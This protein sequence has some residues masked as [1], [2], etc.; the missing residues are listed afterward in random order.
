MVVL[1]ANPRR[2]HLRAVGR[3]SIPPTARPV[4][5]G[6]FE[7]L[8]HRVRFAWRA[9][10]ARVAPWYIGRP[11]G[12]R[13]AQCGLGVVVVWP[14]ALRTPPHAGGRVSTP[15]KAR[16]IGG[17]EL[18][19]PCSLRFN[20]FNTVARGPRAYYP[21]KA[22]PTARGTRACARA[23]RMPAARWKPQL[24]RRTT[25]LHRERD[26]FRRRSTL[27]YCVNRSQPAQHG[28]RARQACVCCHLP[29]DS[30]R[31]GARA[32][33]TRKPAACW[34]SQLARR[35]TVLRR[36]GEA[37]RRCSTLL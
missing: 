16:P 19:I 5:G 31:S 12:A 30:K 4:G 17:G 14:N 35:T 8:D 37:F 6:S 23:M 26:T 18:G 10:H 25:V 32:S 11:R 34:R 24:A 29:R 27:P 21:M 15:P 13:A 9:S 20:S 1:W 3:G 36:K 28:A 2:T 7:S 22:R 33:V